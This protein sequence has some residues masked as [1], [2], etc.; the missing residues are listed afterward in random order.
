[1]LS[2][3]LFCKEN[4]PEKGFTFWEWFYRIL[5]LTSNH[6]QRLWKEGHVMGFVSKQAA[7]SMLHQKQVT[8]GNNAN[9]CFLFRFSEGELGGVTIAYLNF[10]QH[11]WEVLFVSPFTMKDL[12]QRSMVDVIFDLSHLNI[13][14]PDTQ[15]ESLRKF[16]SAASGQTAPAATNGYVKHTLVTHVE[17]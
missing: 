13:L 6:L 1:M 14:Y 8:L 11:G 15:K 12:S 10:G 16:T 3:S 2:W 17:G 4:L 5:L 9:G 7:E